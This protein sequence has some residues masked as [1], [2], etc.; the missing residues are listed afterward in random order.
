VFHLTINEQMNQW[1]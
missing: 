1:N